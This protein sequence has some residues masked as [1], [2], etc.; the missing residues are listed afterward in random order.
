M[1]SYF[2]SCADVTVTPPAPAAELALPPHPRFA[3]PRQPNAE[4]P[5]AI[6]AD[7][8]AELYRARLRR[9]VAMVQLL[10]TDSMG[11]P[12]MSGS[13]QMSQCWCWCTTGRPV[14]LPT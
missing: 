6:A 8:W 1:T 5:D 2:S 3:A 13:S 14:T 9:T 11:T 10:F 4:D 7:A 12:T